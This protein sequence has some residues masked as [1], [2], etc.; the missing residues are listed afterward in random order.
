MGPRDRIER[1]HLPLDD[2]GGVRPCDSCLGTADFRRIGRQGVV[3]RRRYEPTFGQLSKRVDDHS[4]AELR[5]TI[6]QG[7]GG[8]VGRD[9]DGLGRQHRSGIEPGIHLHDADAG[10][11]VP[12]EQRPLDRRGAAPSGQQG[13]VDVDAAIRER[14]RGRRAAGS[15]R[16]RRPP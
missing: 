6:M 4:T 1:S 14:P 8:L 15:A 5:E 3:L 12:R 2:D 10:L 7:A 9:G 13:R 16:K 11:R